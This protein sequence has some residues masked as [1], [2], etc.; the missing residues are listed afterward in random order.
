MSLSE[1]ITLLGTLDIAV[2]EVRIDGSLVLSGRPPGWF[3]RVVPGQSGHYQIKSF[4]NLPYFE[5]FLAEAERFWISGEA[6]LYSGH[7]VQHDIDGFD[8]SLEAWAV[9]VGGRKFVVIKLL[10]P[11][12][13]ELRRSLQKTRESNLARELITSEQ[14]VAKS[15]RRDGALRFTRYC[16]AAISV[17][18]LIIFTL[19]FLGPGGFRLNNHLL[20]WV[21][22]SGL[23]SVVGLIFLTR[24]R[25]S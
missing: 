24:S 11:D 20:D 10:G 16:L 2:L 9:R 25:S 15:H 4:G 17:I 7:W 3:D 21:G 5:Q 13:E 6:R 18:D 23:G 1:E 22:L 19:E 8:R 12:F 14:A